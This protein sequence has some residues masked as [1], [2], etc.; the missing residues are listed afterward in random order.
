MSTGWYEPDAKG[1]PVESHL[2]YS[3]QPAVPTKVIGPCLVSA[4]A[5]HHTAVESLA[6]FGINVAFLQVS[7]GD[8]SERASLPFH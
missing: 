1:G 4:E 6:L 7:L 5:A 8:S 2:S 3:G